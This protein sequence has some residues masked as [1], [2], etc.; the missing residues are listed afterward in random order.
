[1]ATRSLL[2]LRYL[3]W[4]AIWIAVK[5]HFKLPERLGLNLTCILKFLNPLGFFLFESID[6]GLDLYS[7]LILLI[8]APYQVESLLLPLEGGLVCT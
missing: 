1:M 4:K 8:N 7:L 3:I 2:A 6:F 5:R